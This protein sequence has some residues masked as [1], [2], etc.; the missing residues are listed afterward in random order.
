M[1]GNVSLSDLS[2]ESNEVLA[3]DVD[4]NESYAN[5]TSDIA[6]VE[7][8]GD[9]ERV[10][11]VYSS[12]LGRRCV[13]RADIEQLQG[14]SAAYPSLKRLLHR[15]PPASFSMEPSQTNYEVSMESFGRTAY[16]AVVKALREIIRFLA[17]NFKRLWKFLSQNAQRTSAVDDLT[18]KLKGIQQYI[19][20]VD[21]VMSEMPVAEEFTKARAAVFESERH[22]VTKTWN[23]FRNT[24][25][26][27]PAVSREF[28]DVCAGVLQE[29]VAPFA[30]AVEAFLGELAT[31]DSPIAIQTAIA[32]MELYSSA[33]GKLIALASK[34]GFRPGHVRIA[35]NMTPFHANA[36]YIKSVFRSWSNHRMEISTGVFTS[37]VVGL[38]VDNWGSV[39]QDA[40]RSSGARTERM[41]K[42]IEAFDSASLRPGME[43]A[44]SETLVPF[45]KALLSIIQGFT[46][47]EN[48]LGELIATRDNAVIAISRA[49]LNIAK[50]LD[51][52]TRKHGDK[53]T[54]GAKTVIAARRR[55]VISAM[56]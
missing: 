16:E 38:Q 25:V 19:V 24:I 13:C 26:T 10:L 47:L 1:T 49:S 36:A 33:N 18:D 54:I 46:I 20:E 50:N 32:K 17:E 48:C 15:Y 55:A 4:P 37:A 28:L 7:D 30:E 6:Y 31:A 56:S 23:E 43:D 29:S 52:F 11:D 51:G 3:E 5:Q 35:E 14:L 21:R 44:Y 12:I 42:D 53:L 27:N 41:L 40:V 9:A 2:F 22:N 39:V 8:L 34:H 45:F